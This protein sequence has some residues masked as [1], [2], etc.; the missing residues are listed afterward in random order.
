VITGTASTLPILGKG[1]IERAIK[2]RRR[3]PMFIVD[4]A[5]RATSSPT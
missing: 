1:L 4:F 2:A 3:R 5:C